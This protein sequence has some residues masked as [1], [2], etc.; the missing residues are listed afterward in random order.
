MCRNFEAPTGT[1]LTPTM[2]TTRPVI[3]VGNRNARRWTKRAKTI[4]TSPATIV[5]PRIKGSPP[6]QAAAI[7]AAKKFGPQR[8]GQRNPEP[9]PRQRIACRMVPM[10]QAIMVSA[11]TACTCA[12][13][14]ADLGHQHDRQD[15][16]ARHQE[17]VL[18][19][20]QRQR[21][22]GRQIVDAVDQPGGFLSHARLSSTFIQIGVA[23]KKSEPTTRVSPSTATLRT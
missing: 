9:M 23:R 15:Q 20:Q 12:E 16:R 18:D 5:M 1:R 3:S 19:R 11:T 10:P 21:W 2:N 6:S 17:D 7:E 13:V 8:F 14:A 22:P 4:S